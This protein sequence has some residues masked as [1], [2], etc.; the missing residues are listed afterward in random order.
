VGIIEQV[1]LITPVTGASSGFGR[2]MANSLAETVP[3][4]GQSWLPMPWSPWRTCRSERD[5]YAWSSIRPV[6]V[7]DLLSCD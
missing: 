4:D 2:L 7:D 6:M 5:H 3:E 1:V